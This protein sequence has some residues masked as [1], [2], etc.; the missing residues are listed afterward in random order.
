V[1]VV[2]LCSCLE[3]GRDGVGDYTR[4]LAA[5]LIRQGHFSA[6]LSLNDKY[7]SEKLIDIQQS[8]GA[9]LPVLRL[10]ASWAMKVRL[11]YAKKYIDDFGPDWL[12]LQFVIF[13]FHRKGLPIGLGNQLAF[14]GLG[15]HWHV[16][17][18]ELWLGM[19]IH[20]SKMHS[21]WGAVQRQLIKSLIS[22]LNPAIIHTNTKLYQKQLAELGFIAE[23]LPLFGNIPKINDN[24]GLNLSRTGKSIN[25]VIFGNI[26][27]NAPIEDFANEAANYISKNGMEICLT[28][29]GRCGSEQE[30]WASKWKDAG[31]AVNILGEQPANNI[32][33]VLGAASMGISTTPVAL[34]EKSG[35]VAAML[36]HGLPVICV[37]FPWQPKNYKE[38]KISAGIV[39]YQKGNLESIFESR[40]DT[41]TMNS[42]SVITNQLVNVLSNNA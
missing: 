29:I 21:L 31:M 5:E 11:S 30:R 41:P 22:T 10:P 40:F 3:P 12:S 7:I 19:E 34:V 8:E 26:F 2:F 18:H 6:A 14:L 42:V 33:K 13:G 16:M 24:E 1:K 38:L 37:P 32:S 23:Q 35:S 39:F 25:L 9:D 36:E 27:P 17:F 28:I 4:R 15:R 20:S